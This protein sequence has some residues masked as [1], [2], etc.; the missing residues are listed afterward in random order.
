[1]NQVRQREDDAQFNKMMLRFRE[2]KIRRLEATIDGALSEEACRSEEVQALKEELDLMRGRL[3]RNPELTRF[4]MENIRLRDQFQRQV[5]FPCMIDIDFECVTFISTRFE[6][7]RFHCFNGIFEPECFNS[8]LLSFSK[9]AL[10][11]L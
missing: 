6:E 9:L 2:D 11:T 10:Q 1:M 4:A 8:I 5:Y 3:D 7:V